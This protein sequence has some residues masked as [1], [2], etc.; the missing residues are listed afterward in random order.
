MLVIVVLGCG[1]MFMLV[2]MELIMVQLVLECVAFF[3][4]SFLMLV[5]FVSCSVTFFILRQLTRTSTNPR[6]QSYL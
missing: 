4:V 6:V 2:V 1:L 3:T 5:G